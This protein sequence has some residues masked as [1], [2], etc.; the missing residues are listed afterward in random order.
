[1]AREDPTTVKMN[2]IKP[3]MI[4]A[5]SAAVNRPGFTGDHLSYIA[6]LSKEWG[7]PLR[8]VDAAGVEPDPSLFVKW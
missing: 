8:L 1:M 7:P 6:K 2:A 4:V 5:V 3:D